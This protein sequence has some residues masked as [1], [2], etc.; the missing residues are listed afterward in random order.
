MS[1]KGTRKT[2]IPKITTSEMEV[3][4]AKYFN[5]RQH[6]IVPNLSWGLT[7]MHECDLF[8]VRKSGYAIEVEIKRTKADLLAD[9]KKYHNHIDRYNR[10]VQLYYAIPEELLGSCESLIPEPA[11]IIVCKKYEYLGKYKIYASIHREA[12]RRS[13]ARRLTTEEQLKVASLGTM[14]IWSLKEKLNQQK[15]KNGKK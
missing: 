13:D 2:K 5:I 11:G 1:V 6:I 7:G 10:I 15:Y 4:I 14:R 9:F 3:S 8:I 12:K